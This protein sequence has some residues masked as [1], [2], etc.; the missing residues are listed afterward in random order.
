MR[1]ALRVAFVVSLLGCAF[2][3]AHGKGF[4]RCL[5]AEINL[6][7]V[8]LPQSDKSTDARA[9]KKTT[10]KMR[11]VEVN[12]RCQK[13]RLVDG[14]GRR[15]HFYS[16]IG[17][18]G[19]PLRTTLNCFNSRL[20]RSNDWKEGL[21]LF[22]YRALSP[23]IRARSVLGSSILLLR[24]ATLMARQAADQTKITR[25]GFALAFSS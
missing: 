21:G 24:H 17:C 16:L 25:S 14:K 2:T 8:V 3:S 11:L 12:A 4:E 6:D 1:K 18:W 19:N 22:R 5:P 15:I 7:L 9:T 13:G 20:R 10:V 23:S